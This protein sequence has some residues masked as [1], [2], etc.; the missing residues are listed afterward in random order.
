AR[1]PVYSPIATVDF[2][3]LGKGKSVVIS[4]DLDTA[5]GEGTS[6]VYVSPGYVGCPYVDSLY[7]QLCYLT[8]IDSS[9]QVAD[10]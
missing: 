2:K 3:T 8:T 9:F 6:A 1:I 10:T 4:T 5:P 7:T